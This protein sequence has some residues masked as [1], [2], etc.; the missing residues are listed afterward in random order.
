MDIE[1]ESKKES[2]RMAPS[3]ISDDGDLRTRTRFLVRATISVAAGN[4]QKVN[5]LMQGRLQAVL[6][7]IDPEQYFFVIEGGKR[8]IYLVVSVKGTHE[9][10]KIAEALW[11]GLNAEVEFLPAINQADFEKARTAVE[12]VVSSFLTAPTP[13]TE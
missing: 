12:E 2:E 13:V 5:P 6:T 10:P 9:V 11:V 4:D 7:W 8:C 3:S 1:R